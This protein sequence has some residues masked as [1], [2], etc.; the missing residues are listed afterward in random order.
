M[1]LHVAYTIAPYCV[2]VSTAKGKRRHAGYEFGRRAGLGEV[3]LDYIARR[4]GVNNISLV[5]T[6]DGYCT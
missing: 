2:S 6:L 5:M 4:T 3:A 1:T